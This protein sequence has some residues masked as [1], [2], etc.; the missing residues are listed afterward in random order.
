MGTV[1][2]RF[3]SLSNHEKILFAGYFLCNFFHNTIYAILN[4]YNIIR[5]RCSGVSYGKEFSSAGTIVL[6]IYPG[7]RVILGDHVTIVS[8]SRRCTAAALA[9]PSRF[10]T[11]TPSSKIIIGN[12]VGLNGTSITS[13]SRTI[14]IGEDSMIAPNVIIVDSDF[15]VPWPPER[16]R[17]YCGTDSDG[18][19]RIGKNC[20]IGMNSVILKG[21]TI[22]DNSIIGAGSIVNTDIP[23]DSLAAGVPAKVVKTYGETK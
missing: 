7:S 6:D 21:V 17:D 23:A 1:F 8:D 4:M 14:T 5:F 19:V 20:W 3:W 16:R 15:H 10:R 13:R 12:N 22:G 9:F 11:F 18:E 2:S